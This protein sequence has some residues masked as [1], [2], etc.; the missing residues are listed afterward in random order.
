V[1][2]Q[3]CYNLYSCG[4]SPSS[5]FSS[6]AYTITGVLPAPFGYGGSRVDLPPLVVIALTFS[7][8]VATGIAEANWANCNSIFL[9]KIICFLTAEENYPF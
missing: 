4:K 2:Q 5:S 1:S 3:S 7:W 6:S 9:L 8:L